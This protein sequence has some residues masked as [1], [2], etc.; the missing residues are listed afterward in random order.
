MMPSMQ[1][2]GVGPGWTFLTRE[3]PVPGCRLAEHF[4]HQPT[5]QVRGCVHTPAEGCRTAA[6]PCA[7]HLQLLTVCKWFTVQPVRLETWSGPAPS[8]QKHNVNVQRFL[9]HNGHAAFIPF[10]RHLH[11]VR[12]ALHMWRMW[13]VQGCPD[14]PARVQTTLA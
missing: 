11:S 8:I 12:R 2:P 9:L 13:S 5:Q 1:P 6:G 4:V 14:V 3:P 10:P 7:R